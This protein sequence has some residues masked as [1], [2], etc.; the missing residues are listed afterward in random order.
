MILAKLSLLA[1]FVKNVIWPIHKHEYRKFFP[2]SALMFCVLFNQNVLRILKDS[3]LIAEISAEVTGFAKVYCVTPAAALFVV[4]YAKMVNH[5]SF[6]QIYRYLILF[7]TIYFVLFAFVFFPNIDLFHMDPARLNELM[8]AYP[9]WKWYIALAGNWCFILYYVLAELWPNI[10]YILLFWQFANEITETQEAKRFYTLFSLFGNSSLIFVGF[11]MMN[12]SSESSVAAKF[13]T[14]DSK[15]LLIQVS[16]AILVIVSF[17]SERMVKFLCD[18]ILSDPSFYKKAK[19]ERSTK[20]KMGLLESFRY[21]ASSKYLWLMLI[22]SAAFGLTMNL[23]EAVWKAKIKELYPTLNQF[24]EINSLYI[25]WTGVSIMILTIVGN[26]VMRHYSWLT[27]ALITPIVILIT[28]TLFFLLVVFDQQIHTALDGLILISPLALAV[29]VGAVQNVLAKGTKYS[30]WDTS[31][32]MLYIPLDD[33]LRTKGKA[34]VDVVS[35]KI[36]KSSSG[37]VQA[38]LFTIFPFATYNT[39]SPF[40]AVIFI[41]VCIAWIYAVGKIYEEY[42][43]IV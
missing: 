6:Y 32:E 40:M 35:S 3:I 42:Q 12:L 20:E 27:A 36:G 10:F 26:N 2:M 30:I 33:E 8:Q 34:A 17:L 5:L 24:A 18:N 31:R 41:A 15:V 43:K 4:I 7:F 9:H 23:V 25:M 19:R 22:C 11:I 38:V 13:F 21:I 14:T 39:I 1:E 16:T 37:L 29:F 28:G